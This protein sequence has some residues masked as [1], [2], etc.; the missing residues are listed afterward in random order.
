MN[1]EEFLQKIVDII[2]KEL[3][4]DYRIFLFGSWAKDTAIETSDLDVGVLGPQ[5]IPPD[6]FSNIKALISA[7]PT[8]RKADVV[9]LVAMGEEFRNNALSYAKEL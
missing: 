7:I 4:S 8:L 5:E 6:K 1:R 3:G 9:D 2:K